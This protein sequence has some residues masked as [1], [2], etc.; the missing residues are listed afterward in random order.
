MWS[1]SRRW[2]APASAGPSTTTSPSA[3]RDP[4]AVARTKTLGAGTLSLVL[5][6]AV[7]YAMPGAAALAGAL[8]LGFVSYG[9]SV[10]LAVEAL[11]RLGAAREA[12]FF[13]T[14]PFVGAA[15]AVP[16]LGEA[17]G[18]RELLAATILG[19]GVV[20]LLREEHAH[21]HVH[22]AMEHDHAHVHDEH[23]RHDH[24][25]VV[26]E[27][28]AHRHVHVPL[29]HAHPHVSDAHHRHRH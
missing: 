10:V 15:A 29:T 7:G 23:H 21:R 17:V 1:A 8:A 26:D 28:H 16:L 12:A 5:A 2:R 27:P 20:V 24:D 22:E 14:A 19:C 4:L 6:V 3:L 13:A 18:L 9:V 25:G 11:R